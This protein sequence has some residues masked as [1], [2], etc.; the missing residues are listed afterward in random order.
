MIDD[1]GALAAKATLPKD[2]EFAHVQADALLYANLSA[3]ICTDRTATRLSN[4]DPY[5]LQLRTYCYEA[6]GDAAAADL[7]RAV[8]AAKGNDDAAFDVLLDDAFGG[9]AKKAPPDQAHPTALDVYLLRRAGLPVTNGE[10]APLGTAAN[11]LAVRDAR[12]SPDDRLAAAERIVSTGALDDGELKKLA[13]AQVFTTAQKADASD[14]A[15]KLS[16]LTREA[17]LRQ[18]AAT[19]TRTAARLALV[20]RADPILNEPGP[21]HVFAA[22]EAGNVASLVPDPALGELSWIAARTTML[23]GKLESVPGW[24]GPPSD[25]LTAQAGLALD[26]AAPDADHDARAAANI[27]WLAAHAASD[28]WPAS[29]ALALGLWQALGHALPADAIPAAAA[30]ATQP[31]DGDTLNGDQAQAL[32]AAAAQPDRLGEAVLLILDTI[33]MRG[34]AHLS[35]STT[36]HVVSV[37][38]KIGLADS[39]RAFAEEALLLGPPAPAAIPAGPAPRAAQ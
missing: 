15:A 34:P 33:G 5:W 31:F 3:D 10:A 14:A 28:G 8:L 37:L 18:A 20:K 2:P 17:L 9:S 32:D 23:G 13:D 25:P 38:Q 1:A 4:A 6:A 11:L 24:I 7:T 30:L 36:V 19:E 21:F 16:F 29:S 12:N 22:L 39:A 27:E 26:I 35:P